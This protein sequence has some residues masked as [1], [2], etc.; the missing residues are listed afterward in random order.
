MG[1]IKYSVLKGFNV[2]A[3]LAQLNEKVLIA[4]EEFEKK[5]NHNIKLN[6]AYDYS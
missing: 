3:Q 4:L 6:K 5:R 2:T 1:R